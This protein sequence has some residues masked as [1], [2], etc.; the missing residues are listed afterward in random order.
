MSP[1]LAPSHAAAAVRVVGARN[2]H[3]Q[4]PDRPP[5]LDGA[6][7]ERPVILVAILLSLRVLTPLQE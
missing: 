3:L 4:L 7:S 5:G 1:T 2:V 6:L